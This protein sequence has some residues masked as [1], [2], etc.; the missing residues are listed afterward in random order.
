MEMNTETK[1]KQQQQKQTHK[2]KKRTEA[3]NQRKYQM[4]MYPRIRGIHLHS[5]VYF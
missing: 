4:E 1:Q 3:T 5:C 2:K